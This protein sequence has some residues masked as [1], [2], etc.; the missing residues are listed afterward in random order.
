MDAGR[1]CP[2]L[3]SLPE[4]LPD[5]AKRPLGGQRASAWAP[6]AETKEVLSLGSVQSE[7]LMRGRREKD[8]VNTPISVFSFD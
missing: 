6:V 4:M 2:P 8:E 1:N 3:Y 5:P 7:V